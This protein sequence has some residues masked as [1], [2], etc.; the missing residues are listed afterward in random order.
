MTSLLRLTLDLCSCRRLSTVSLVF[1]ASSLS[2]IHCGFFCFLRMLNLLGRSRLYVLQKTAEAELP[3]SQDDFIWTV[4]SFFSVCSLGPF[5]THSSLL[6]VHSC[7]MLAKRKQELQGHRR[8]YAYCCFACSKCY[9]KL[10]ALFPGFCHSNLVPWLAIANQSQKSK[11]IDT[12]YGI[13]L[14]KENQLM[15]FLE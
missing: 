12:S 6:Y 4:K 11:S 9:C 13:Q 14:Y 7:H 2:S 8:L 15:L 10:R 3:V 5:T 1:C